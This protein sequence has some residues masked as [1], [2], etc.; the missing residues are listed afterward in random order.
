ME[1]GK[2]CFMERGGSVKAVSCD[3]PNR[4]ASWNRTAVE[5][6]TF[7]K[8]ARLFSRYGLFFPVSVWYKAYRPVT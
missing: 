6:N 7:S 4:T 3:R 2:G 5:I 1:K 8:D